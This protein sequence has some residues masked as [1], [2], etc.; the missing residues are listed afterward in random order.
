MF[1]FN[2]ACFT[3]GIDKLSIP[4]LDRQGCGMGAEGRES[5]MLR[6]GH[7]KWYGQS[8]ILDRVHM[9]WMCH[10]FATATSK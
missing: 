6:H 8:D 1:L 3:L 10:S 7:C 2:I 4:A 9:P 5:N